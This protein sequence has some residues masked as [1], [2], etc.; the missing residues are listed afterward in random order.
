[1]KLVQGP[2]DHLNVS[3]DTINE[4]ENSILL[5]TEVRAAKPANHIIYKI[6]TLLYRIGK[7]LNV[8][9]ILHTKKSYL[10]HS[11]KDTGHLFTIMM[12]LD[13]YKYRPFGV[14]NRNCKSIYLFDAWPND[15]QKIQD[16]CIKYKIDYLFI[17]AS[18]SAYILQQKLDYTKV[19]WIPEGID[20]NQYKYQNYSTKTIDVLALGRKYDAY[21][22][23]IV[24]ELL[25]RGYSYL[26]EKQKG[27]LVFPTREDFIQGLASSKI[28]ICVPSNITHPERSGDVETMTIRYLQSMASKCLIV[29]HAPAEMIQLF[30]YNP[31][32]EIDMTNA[33][34]QLDNILK[35]YSDYI[36]LIEKNYLMVLENHTWNHRWSQI[37]SIFNQLC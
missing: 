27:E 35:N 33:V 7:K 22:Q 29:G 19:R 16:F 30:G 37:K 2:I 11:C 32:I 3:T 8:S 25:E 9:T 5:N 15:Y 10:K 34:L 14:L 4:F 12:G 31:V 17:T 24:G 36:P 6:K 28:S 13:E 1:M 23:L 18:Q 21:H 26:Y 20:V